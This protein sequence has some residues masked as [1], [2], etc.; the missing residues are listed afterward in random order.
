MTDNTEEIENFLQNIITSMTVAS[1][2]ETS[3]YINNSR[4]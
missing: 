4:L 2:I 3:Q 1:N